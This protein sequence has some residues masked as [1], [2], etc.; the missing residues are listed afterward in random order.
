MPNICRGSRGRWV[1]LGSVLAAGGSSRLDQLLRLFTQPQQRS[2]D[3]VMLTVSSS[4]VP[5]HHCPLCPTYAN[6][7]LVVGLH[8]PPPLPERPPVETGQILRSE[9]L[10]YLFALLPGLNPEAE[11]WRHLSN[12]TLLFVCTSWSN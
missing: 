6:S 5:N 1:Q 3:R 8:S 4:L 11:L 9:G 7:P 12:K 10:Y 2:F